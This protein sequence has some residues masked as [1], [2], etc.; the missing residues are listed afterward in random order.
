VAHETSHI[1]VLLE[2]TV[3]ALNVKADGIY[4]DATYGRGGHSAAVLA[5]LN[6]S[7][8]LFA[9][10]RD[11]EAVTNA[12]ERFINDRRFQVVQMPF[13][14]LGDYLADQHVAGRVNG[15]LMDL[16]V[17]SPQLD[18][19]QR[20]FS[21]RFYGPLDMR[22]DPGSGESAAQ[23]VNRAS[24]KELADVIHHYGEERF[25]RRIARA[26][27][28]LRQTSPL[29]TT[30]DLADLVRRTVPTRETGQDAATRTFQAI[31]IYLNQELSE[32]E[33][34]LPQALEA[35]GG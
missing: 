1:P 32:L 34:A 4:V 35:W 30:Q 33:A 17:S 16:G 18:Q 14:Q 3:Q 2:E 29:E 20:G 5:R 19:A 12:R 21:F 31:R 25:A 11:P 15:I 27:V 28:K 7:G 13:S 6:E 10:D 8:R 9:M 22:M 24:E 26:I 23:W